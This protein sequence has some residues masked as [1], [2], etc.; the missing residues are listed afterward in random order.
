MGK[1]ATGFIDL[2]GKIE[3]GAVSQM[4]KLFLFY[5]EYIYIPGNMV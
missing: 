3:L 1:G 5:L 4:I 2:H